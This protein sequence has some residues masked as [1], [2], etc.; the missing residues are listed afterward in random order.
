MIIFMSTLHVCDEF[1]DISKL[2]CIYGREWLTISRSYSMYICMYMVS[3]CVATLCEQ[4]L[5][6]T[7]HH[8]CLE[9]REVIGKIW[10]PV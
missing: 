2:S 9:G 8:V 5:E 10:S 4:L 6:S 7:Y 1:S 3:V